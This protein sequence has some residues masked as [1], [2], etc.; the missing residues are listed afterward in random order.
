M[1]LVFDK[2]KV[3]MADVRTGFAAYAAYGVFKRLGS[4]DEAICDEDGFVARMASHLQ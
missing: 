4:D 2:Y 3:G 1:T